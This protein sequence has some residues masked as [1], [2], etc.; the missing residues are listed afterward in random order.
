MWFH[1]SRGATFVDS[2][3]CD[4]YP[5]MFP[6]WIGE[7]ERCRTVAED[8]WFHA[9]KLQEGD[10]IVDV[11]AGKGEDTVTFSKCA[12][13]GGRVNAIEAHPVTYRC[14]RVFASSIT[15]KTSDC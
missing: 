2:P 14:L 15:F 8:H 13:R 7:F 3:N 10:L 6:T 11:A 9:Y 12:G 5:P 4:Y 1:A